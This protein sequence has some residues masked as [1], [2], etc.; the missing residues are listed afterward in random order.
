[1]SLKPLRIA[2]GG[3]PP[4]TKVRTPE[5]EMASGETTPVG[6]TGGPHTKSSLARQCGCSLRTLDRARALG[7]VPP[8][9]WLVGRS[10]RWGQ[11]TITT[12]LATRPRIG[13]RGKVVRH[14]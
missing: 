13:G 14:G 7:Q 1:M 10:P 4:L 8:P 11:A 9:D 5:P 3:Q 6:L 12:W 2:M